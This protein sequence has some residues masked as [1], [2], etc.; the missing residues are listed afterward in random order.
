M[1]KV[2]LL[3]Q[4]SLQTD[5][6]IVELPSRPA[7]SLLAYLILNAGTLQRREKLAGLLWP[8]ATETNARS[9]LR[10]TLWRIR[11]SLGPSLYGPDYINADDL[12]ITFDVSAPYW[13]DTAV[14]ERKVNQHSPLE[15]LIEAVSVYRGELLPGFYEEWV[16]LERERLQTVFERKMQTLLERLV[17]A[18]RWPDVLEWGERW[19]ALGHI[20]EPAY[21]ALM[22]AHSGLGDRAR[23]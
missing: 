15:E 9:N 2:R 22:L 14:L 7:Q 21:R 17:E 6:G 1:L 12:T 5:D 18:Q 19:L 13:L 11:K 4:F 16:V 10:H 20:P 23:S 3:G 8:E